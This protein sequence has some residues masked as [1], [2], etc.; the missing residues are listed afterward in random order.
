MAT[1]DDPPR[2][3]PPGLDIKMVYVTSAILTLVVGGMVLWCALRSAYLRNLRLLNDPRRIALARLMEEAERSR[4]IPEMKTVNIQVDLEMGEGAREWHHV[5]PL[6]LEHHPTLPPPY[7]ESMKPTDKNSKGANFVHL[8]VL[9]MLPSASRKQYRK[10]ATFEAALANSKD[11]PPETIDTTRGQFDYDDLFP[12][13]SFGVYH[14]VY[15]D[16]I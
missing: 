10:N 3:D 8:A 11:R 7:N 15:K 2:D 5:M 9:V 14:G 1:W 6:S 13:A 16:D 12:E 4:P